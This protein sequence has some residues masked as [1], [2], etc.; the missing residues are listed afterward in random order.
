MRRACSHELI[1][2]SDKMIRKIVF[3]RCLVK[4][5]QVSIGDC[6]VD[7]LTLVYID[8]LCLYTSALFLCI[9]CLLLFVWL[10]DG[11]NTSAGSALLFLI[12]FDTFYFKNV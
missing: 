7:A 10:V 12:A 2:V 4:V 8:C 6:K 9:Y 1:N 11:S 5:Y 3:I